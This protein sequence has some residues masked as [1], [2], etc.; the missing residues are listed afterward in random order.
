[1]KDNSDDSSNEEINK[2]EDDNNETNDKEELENNDQ[3][4]MDNKKET[5]NE[6]I[7]N[8]YKRISLEELF[9]QKLTFIRGQNRGRTGLVNIGNTCFMNSALQCLSNCYELTKYFLLNLYED[10]INTQN[11][12]G[13]GGKIAY[14]YNKLL[15]DLWNGE[16]NY[17]NP[18]YFKNIFAHFVRKFSGYHQQDSNEFLIYLLD[19]IHEDLNCITKKPYIEI[20]EKTKDETDE[21]ASKRWWEKHLMRENSIIVDLFHGQFKSTITCDFCKRVSVS[22]DSFIFLSLPIPSGKYEIIIKYFGHDINDFLDIKLPITENTSV[23]NIIDV[24]K[25]KLTRKNKTIS[26]PPDKRKRNRRNKKKNNKKN[27]YEKITLDGDFIEIVLLTKDK[28]LYKVFTT[29]DYIFPYIQ[30][31]YELVAYEK[32]DN[33]E[34]IYFY[35]TQYYYSYIFSLFYYPK[36]FIFN[37]PFAINIDKDQGLFTIY[38]NIRN[39]LEKLTSKNKKEEV[40]NVNFNFTKIDK[41]NEKECGFSI[42]LNLYLAKKNNSICESIFGFSKYINDPLLY[43][44]SIKESISFLKRH[45]NL[46]EDDDRLCLDIDIHFD[47]DKN[48]L[49]K[50]KYNSQK[51]SL[52]YEND[53]NLYDCL[54]LFD[55]EEILEGDNEWYCNICKKHR[56]V[57]KKMDIFKCPYY[58]IIQLKRFKQDSEIGQRSIFNIF[59]SSKNTTLV[60][61][62]VNN[63]DLSNY[64][65]SKENKGTKYDLIG[66]INHYGGASFGH[67]TAYCLN[68]NEWCEYNDESVSYINENNVVSN[69]AYVLFYKRINN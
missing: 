1:M 2:D 9:N 19:R 18:G 40:L 15:D 44:C 20:G 28:K 62:P 10:D 11:R 57:Y 32:K 12:L 58:L 56:E 65:L 69:A 4:D 47:I 42:Y 7:S 36:T 6:N 66:V 30:K 24:I 39:F 50:L 25:N 14:I 41:N 45:L 61:F 51:I 49:P 35:L 59:N 5:N 29:N 22:F 13:S 27:D 3:D 33:K 63:F 38:E 53:I 26:N 68:D 55:S 60:E 37:Y 8:N 23:Q 17:I 48:K 64:I 54:N 67:Y 31:G 34:N 21:E 16:K 43:N 52:S 46:E